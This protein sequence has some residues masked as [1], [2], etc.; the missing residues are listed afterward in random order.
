[1]TSQDSG[2]D[3]D[4]GDDEDIDLLAGRVVVYAAMLGGTIAGQ[5]GGIAVGALLGWSSIGLPLGI[6]VALEALAGARVGARRSG[7]SLTARQAGQIS[8]KYSL[9]LL[10]IS[11]PMVGWMA[12]AHRV[13]GRASFWT[14]ATL[15]IAIAL[16]AVA[17][18]ARW[19]LMIVLA[20]PRRRA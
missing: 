12:A 18:L 16:L 17:T 19:G 6:S 4:D 9:G 13:E 15:A 3:G 11:V 1:V 7:G 20:R 2:D 5:L 8:L 14:P 10:A